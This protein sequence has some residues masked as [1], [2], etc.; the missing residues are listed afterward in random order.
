[1]ATNRFKIKAPF[2]ADGDQPQAI[3][4]LIDG[5]KNHQAA[6]TLL[7]VT[8]SGKTFT[9]AHVIEAIQRPTLVM[10]PNKTLAAQ[11]ASEFRLFFPNN[12]V[13]YFVSY[14]DYYQPEAYVPSTDTY[15]EKETDINDEI[16]RLRH[17][18]TA[19]LLSRRDVIIVAS[20]SCIYGLGSPEEYAAQNLWLA[21]DNWQS[22]EEILAKLVNIFYTRS[23]ILKRGTFRAH[24]GTIEI[25]PPDR[26]NILRLEIGKNGIQSIAEFDGLTRAPVRT[27]TE[28]VIFPA[29]HFIA[30]E[31][32]MKRALTSIETDLDKSL[33]TFEK[34]GK[35]LEAERLERRT[36]Q[37]LEL[38]RQIGTCPGVENYS[39][40]FT[41][42]A[43]GEAPSTLI[44]FFPKDFLLVVDES[45][46]TIPQI[47][48]MYEGDRARKQ[49]LV[50]Y[51]FRLPAAL[52]NR[53][54]KFSE[55]EAKIN[56]AIYV[57]ATPSRYELDHSRA[58][59]RV[60]NSEQQLEKEAVGD[61]PIRHS[62][63]AIRSEGIIEQVV[64]PTGLID[65]E[66]I[67]KTATNQISD[68]IKEIAK[69]TA[70]NDRVLIT[71]LTKKQAEQLQTHLTEKGF[72]AGYLHSEVDTLERIKTLE[73]LR[74]G[75]IDILVGVNLLREGLDLPEVALVAILDADKEGF[76][77]SETSLIQTMGRAARNIRGRVILY[78]DRTT[79]SMERAIAEAKRRRQIQVQY[80]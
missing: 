39:R 3:K 17:A 45:H 74:R 61:V 40:Y 18:A 64:R 44:D 76:L 22:R 24:G 50:D 43:S 55:F 42:R 36:R 25:M 58:A 69:V 20:V 51:G 8:G 19:A 14:Y 70:D 62:P 80:N 31:D 77:R 79:G 2:K 54:L 4:Q 28:T 48:G 73:K 13:G 63:F 33:K 29:K 27:Y 47:G 59:V 9:I 6:Q 11:L 41:G 53:P 46:V 38:L 66:I 32:M 34:E 71:T 37:D 78:A 68:V 56:Q 49:N 35:L 10:A 5:L 57:S 75:N 60:A 7:G 23:E 12:S 65:P 67:I 72:L 26:E 21:V 52:D 30:S 16:D 15:I 1:M